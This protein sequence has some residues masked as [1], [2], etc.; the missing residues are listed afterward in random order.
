MMRKILLGI[1]ITGCIAVTACEEL[2]NLDELNGEKIILGLKDALVHG[3]DTAVTNLSAPDG[4]F[5]DE[6][7]KILLPEEAEPVYNVLNTLPLVSDLLDETILAIN[8][9][10]EDAATE[11][12]P[13]FIDAIREM[14]ID[15]GL[16]IL[17][18]PDT[19]ATTY[20]KDKTYSKLFDAFKP[21]IET[22]L[23]KEIVF[24]ISAEASYAKLID[25]Y[26]AIPLVSDIQSNSLSEHTTNRALRGIFKKVGD[27]EKLIREDPAHRVTDI[28]QE[29]FGSQD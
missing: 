14:T 20:L 24:G 8:R 23:S 9:S 5:R 1:A 12:K 10:A 18:G 21:K 6:A 13:I 11:A 15:D 4:F 28:L 19:A 26:N 17:N 22:S 7:V 16:T 25:T 3:T 2:N 27:E 29:V